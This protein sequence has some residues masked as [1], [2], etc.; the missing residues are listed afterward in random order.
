MK[1][2]LDPLHLL[3]MLDLSTSKNVSRGCVYGI[4]A[5]ILQDRWVLEL[6]DKFLENMQLPTTDCIYLVIIRLMF[7]STTAIIIAIILPISYFT[8]LNRLSKDYDEN[9]IS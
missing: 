9:M 5:T 3:C 2:A 8:E 1:G 4:V 6:H 7:S